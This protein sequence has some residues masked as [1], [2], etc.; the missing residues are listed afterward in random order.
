MHNLFCEAGPPA[1]P[2]I[3]T[4]RK[5]DASSSAEKKPGAEKET[6]PDEGEDSNDDDSDDDSDE[7][8]PPTPAAK[9]KAVAKKAAA[10]KKAKDDTTTPKKKGGKGKSGKKDAETQAVKLIA[11]MLTV[12]TKARTLI[13]QI[14]SE[15]CW[16]WANNEDT[17]GALEKKL[18]KIDRTM[19]EGKTRT[20]VFTPLKKLKADFDIQELDTAFKTFLSQL[21]K[22]TQELANELSSVMEQDTIRR[23]YKH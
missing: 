17:M 3:D 16:A 20:I 15:Q 1:P 21:M 5:R 2:S 9:K 10:K 7:E 4:K 6:D 18:N 13:E 22:P 14:K 19:R 11:E 23:K 8:A 12:T